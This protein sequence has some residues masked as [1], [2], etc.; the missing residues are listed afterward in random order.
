MK[1]TILG[2]GCPK[3]R[4]TE[5]VVRQVVDELGLDVEIEKIEDVDEIVAHG[6]M[7]TPAVA[8]DGEIQITGRVPG[9]GEVEQL[10]RESR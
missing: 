2:T 5:H 6:V 10:L 4:S 7:M 1:I 9:R 8:L 3:C